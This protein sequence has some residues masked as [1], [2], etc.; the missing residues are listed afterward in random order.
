M[1]NRLSHSLNEIESHTHTI[2]AQDSDDN[3]VSKNGERIEEGDYVYTRIRGGRHE[4]DVCFLSCYYNHYT[5]PSCAP[6]Y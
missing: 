1:A 3:L 2:K 5:N 6:H 4:G